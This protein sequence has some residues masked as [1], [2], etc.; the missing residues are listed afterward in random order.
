MTARS[1]GQGAPDA[2]EGQD[3]LNAWGEALEITSGYRGPHPFTHREKERLLARL[4]RAVTNVGELAPAGEIDQAEAAALAAELDTTA[5]RVWAFRPLGCQHLTCYGIGPPLPGFS[6]TRVLGRLRLL[7]RLGG[8]ATLRPAVLHKALEGLWTDLAEPVVWPGYEGMRRRAPCLT[9]DV[10]AAL[11]GALDALLQ[12]QHSTVGEEAASPEATQAL[13]QRVR[14]RVAALPA[15]DEGAMD[16]TFLGEQLLDAA[17]TGLPGVVAAL[18]ARGAPV[19]SRGWQ[20]WAAVHHAAARG[21]ADV[22]EALV[23]R[24]ASLDDKTRGSKVLSVARLAGRGGSVELAHLLADAGIDLCAPDDD[25]CTAL[26]EA[27]AADHA[28]LV[29][30]LLAQG[31][32]PDA[33]TT[34]GE[35]TPWDLAVERDCAEVADALLGEAL[36]PGSPAAQALLLGAV[37]KAHAMIVRLLLDRRVDPNGTDGDGRTLVQ[38]AAGKGHTEVLD[39][40][41]AGGA[42]VD[43]DGD[44]ALELLCQAARCGCAELVSLLLDRQAD[45]AR[46]AD[47]AT[48]ALEPAA[49]QAHANVVEVLLAHGAEAPFPKAFADGWRTLSSAAPTDATQGREGEWLRL[50]VSLLLERLPLAQPPSSVLP[51]LGFCARREGLP[52]CLHLATRLGEAE[53]IALLVAHGADANAT[54]EQGRTAL[55]QAA[56]GDG[57]AGAAQ[58]LLASG[59]DVNAQDE[60]GRTPL[61]LAAGVPR[62]DIVHVLVH[63]GADVNVEDTQ[64]RTPLA[65]A[66][67]RGHEP[68]VRAL[69]GQRGGP[70]GPWSVG[71]E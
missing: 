69:L 37:A 55:H 17:S 50:W 12:R 22:V 4:G 13:L 67:E 31:C 38:V 24:G 2:D 28:E 21:H 18:V 5:G 39:G 70:E 33:R 3:L 54:D 30:F 32:D 16:S 45:P 63:H 60:R 51:Y 44:A 15:H 57:T 8:A 34:D 14:E 19:D 25:G 23:S 9:P 20:G 26:H 58:A 47:Q 40:L 35:K 56:S 66:R 36:D 27:A 1:A 48:E 42:A 11:V 41:L 49:S 65:L 46:R 64:G 68:V 62:L 29:R 59:A 7:I 10:K 43:V 61:H 52:S 71:P 6:E 53:T